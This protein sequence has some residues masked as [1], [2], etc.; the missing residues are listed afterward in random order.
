M[1]LLKTDYLKKQFIVDFLS[2]FNGIDDDDRVIKPFL[3]QCYANIADMPMDTQDRF[4]IY[5]DQT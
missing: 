1:V 5:L 2:V 4:L 3:F